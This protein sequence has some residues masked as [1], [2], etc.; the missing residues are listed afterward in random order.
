ML[1]IPAPFAPDGYGSF[2]STMD[3]VGNL[4][5]TN[6]IPNTFV[7]TLDV[8]LNPRNG[9]VRVP[10]GTELNVVDPDHD[11]DPAKSGFEIMMSYAFQIPDLPGDD[12]TAGSGKLSVHI[13]RGIFATD[14]YDPVVEYPLGGPLYCGRD[15]QITSEPNGPVIGITTAPPSILINEIEFLFL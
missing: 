2:I 4:D 15:G 8:L 6:I 5:N 11:G 10:A 3:V 12:T 1:F 9:A 7:S 14:K 13:F